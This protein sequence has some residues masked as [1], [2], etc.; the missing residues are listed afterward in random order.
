MAKSELVANLV[1]HDVAGMHQQVLLILRVFDAVPGWIIACKGDA[2]HTCS[3]ASPAKAEGPGWLRVQIL[4]GAEKHSIVVGW[5]VSRHL[6]KYA[7]LAASSVLFAFHSFTALYLTLKEVSRH[8]PIALAW[9]F[10][11]SFQDFHRAY[12]MVECVTIELELCELIICE[13]IRVG[14]EKIDLVLSWIDPLDVAIAIFIVLKALV[15]L[16]VPLEPV[17]IGQDALWLEDFLAVLRHVGG[18][19]VSWEVVQGADSLEASFLGH[20]GVNLCMLNHASGNLEAE[21]LTDVGHD[22]SIF[23]DLG[24]SSSS[25]T[26]SLHRF[27][28]IH[29]HLLEIS[30]FIFFFLLSLLLFLLVVGCSLCCSDFALL[31]HLG[32]LFAL[33]FL[34]NYT[35]NYFG[36]IPLLRPGLFFL[37]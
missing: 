36:G 1:A 30:Y 25:R 24:S 33:K 26:C 34:L 5:S 8:N 2:S 20:D 22:G 35:I 37:K 18:H 12:T 6:A 16:S 19:Y 13:A 23:L 4:H 31:D 28:H 11:T 7:R 17:A 14:D 21:G 3:E 9:N 15:R 32:G 27:V 29:D 10:G